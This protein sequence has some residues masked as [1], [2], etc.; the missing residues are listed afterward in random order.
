MG[1]YQSS[2]SPGRTIKA[3]LAGFICSAESQPL[4]PCTLE[5]VSLSRR[6]EP[7]RHPVTDG[8]LS[9]WCELKIIFVL[10]SGSHFISCGEQWR[11]LSLRGSSS[12]QIGL[13]SI[14]VTLMFL[15]STTSPMATSTKQSITGNSCAY[16]TQKEQNP[17]SP[18]II[19]L[20]TSEGKKGLSA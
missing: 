1:G 4:T 11:R 6:S 16:R 3:S 8:R 14:V 15:Q 20:L 10:H 13:V 17:E 9:L 12:T 5:E 18:T 2:L 7:P 19:W